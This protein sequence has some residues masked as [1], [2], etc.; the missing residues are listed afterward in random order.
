MFNSIQIMKNGPSR[1]HIQGSKIF[2]EQ[3]LEK[4]GNIFFQKKYLVKKVA[5]CRKTQKETL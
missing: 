2:K 1:L 3:Q 5:Y 4:L